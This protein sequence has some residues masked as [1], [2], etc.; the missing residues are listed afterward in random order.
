MK[1]K[2]LYVKN[3]LTRKLKSCAEKYVDKKNQEK[4]VKY[5][6]TQKLKRCL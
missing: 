6:L 3:M 1:T 5:W 2:E 4:R